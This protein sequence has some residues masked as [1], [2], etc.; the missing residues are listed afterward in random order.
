M[1]RRFLSVRVSDIVLVYRLR[2][3]DK[4]VIIFKDKDFL[5]VIVCSYPT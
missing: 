1:P 5:I 4:A 3:K 2:D